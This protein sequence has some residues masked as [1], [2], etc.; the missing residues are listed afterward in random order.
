M[1]CEE[2]NKSYPFESFLN[3]YQ[4]YQKYGLFTK[5]R[6][7]KKFGY[8]GK[9]LWKDTFNKSPMVINQGNILFMPTVIKK[10]VTG[11]VFVSKCMAYVINNTINKCHF[12]FDM[13]RVHL[14][15]RDMDFTNSEKIISLLSQ[16]KSSLFKDIHRRLIEDLIT[17]FRHENRGNTHLQIKIY[18]FN[19]IWEDM[20]NVYLNKYF[21]KI[22]GDGELIFDSTSGK[23]N[24]FK[25]GKFQ[26]DSRRDETSTYRIE[27]DYYY[28]EGKC[29]YIFDAKY[30]SRIESL[31]YKQISYYFLLRYIDNENNDE[32]ITYNALILPTSGPQIKK[33]HFELD[34]AF[35][36][37]KEFRI[38]EH[39][40]NVREIIRSYLEFS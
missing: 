25:K 36:R 26:L 24:D 29:R 10:G 28:N 20:I 11:Y 14:E 13:P 30:Y 1:R 31:D 40:L 9:I 7:I 32:L 5:E 3:I 33:V 23:I 16:I 27:P 6:E 8:N 22:G 34:K 39:Y 4:Y 18:N 19:L 2:I 37:N 38:I 12:I 35:N 21:L 15:Y 17:Y